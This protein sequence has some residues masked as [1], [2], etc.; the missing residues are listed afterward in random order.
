[1]SNY[2]VLKVSDKK[3]S[4]NVAYHVGVPSENNVAG[5]NLRS[6]VSQSL[7]GVSPSQVPWLQG[8]FSI[9]YAGLQS[10]V[11]YEHVES[12]RFNANLSNANKQLAIDGRFTELVTSIPN[13]IRARFKF[14]GLNRDVP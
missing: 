13:K 12:I 2:H 3:D 5:V 7:S 9:E 14:W 1:M 10:G 11:T 4:A 6:A 8:D